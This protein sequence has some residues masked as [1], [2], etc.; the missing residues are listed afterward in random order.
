LKA[1]QIK[2]PLLSASVIPRGATIIGIPVFV[3]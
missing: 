1:R 3:V 2:Q